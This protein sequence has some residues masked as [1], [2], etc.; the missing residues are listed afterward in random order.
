LL[1]YAQSRGYVEVDAEGFGGRLYI[2]PNP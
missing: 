1:D 2:K